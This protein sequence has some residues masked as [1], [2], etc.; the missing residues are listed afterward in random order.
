MLGAVH[1]HDGYP[2]YWP[3]DPER[4]AAGDRTL[5]AWVAEDD[6]EIVGQSVLA[7]ADV[8]HLWAPWSEAAGVPA[9]RIGVIARFYVAPGL[10]GHGIGAQLFDAAHDEARRRGLAPVLDVATSNADGIAF[11]ER[12]GWR[13]VGEATLHLRDPPGATLAMLLYV[14]PDA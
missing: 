11:Y 14:G 10:R 13:R 5:A 1:A 12:R 2:T 6:G 3:A 9:E 7:G 4:F 8:A